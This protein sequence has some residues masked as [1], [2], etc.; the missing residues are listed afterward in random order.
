MNKTILS[1]F[2]FMLTAFVPIMGFEIPTITEFTNIAF[3]LK[4]EKLIKKL[5][6]SNHHGVDNMTQ[7]F[8]NIKNEIEGTYT[9]KYNVGMCMDTLEKELRRAGLR[10]PEQEMLAIRKHLRAYER[11]K[12]GSNAEIKVSPP[13]LYGAVITLSGLLLEVLPVPDCDLLGKDLIECGVEIFDH[14][15]D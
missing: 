2:L 12:K 7:C 8:F 9:I 14:H 10:A 1:T 15:L 4:M 5:K 6:K 11:K 13:L 3:M